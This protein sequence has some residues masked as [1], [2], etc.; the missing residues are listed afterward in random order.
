MVV[1]T[2]KPQ[3]DLQ[4]HRLDKRVRFHCVRCQKDRTADLI[5]TMG[6]DW[7]QKICL[8]CYGFLVHEQRKPAKEAKK[9]RESAREK[10]R[11]AAKARARMPGAYG[12]LEFLCAVGVRAELVDGWLRISGEQIQ[13]V[14]HLPRPETF[15]WR[16]AVD[17]IVVEHIRET[18]NTAVEDNARFSN[19]LRVVP[20]WSE[21]GFSIIRDDVQ[22]AIIHPTRAYISDGKVIHAKVIHANFMTPGPH[23]QQVADALHR[24]VPESAGWKHEEAKTATRAAAAVAEAELRR[25]AARRQ[26]D[27]LP[28]DLA[29]ERIAACLDASRRIRLE[30]H[31]AYP[32]LV[33]LECDGGELTLLPIAGTI[34]RL[35]VPFRL[36]TGTKTLAGDLV[37]CDRDPLPLLIGEDVPY[38]DAITAWTWALLGFADATCVEYEPTEPAARRELARSRQRPP[39][40]ATHHHPSVRTLSRTSRWPRHLEPVGRWTSYSGSIV[41]AHLRHLPNGQTARDDAHDRAR[42]VGIILRPGETWV[43]AHIRGVPD[44]VE[45]RFRWNAPTEL[46]LFNT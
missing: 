26:I 21:S 28:D 29:P 32:R 33:V 27:Q 9:V 19:G 2:S 41:A 35:L 5:A 38:E 24:T 46:K 4:L 15:E 10:A 31:L 3:G 1:R 39:Y 7:A 40:A 13:R 23:W 30:R 17:R 20:Q 16:K 6:G 25:V 22:L 11:K 45:M 14:D 12:L 43:K 37:L 8:Q 36:R 44:S 42:Q 34:T 18:F